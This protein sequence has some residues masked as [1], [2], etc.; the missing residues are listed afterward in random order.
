MNSIDSRPDLS[1]VRIY[2]QQEIVGAGFLISDKYILTCAHV[3]ATVLGINADSEQKPSE[4]QIVELDFPTIQPIEPLTATVEFWLPVNPNNSPEDIA[5]LKL[6]EPP[7]KESQ[8]AVLSMTKDRLSGHKFEALGFPEGRSGGAWAEG[9]INRCVGYGWIQLTDRQVPGYRLEEGFSGTP[10]WDNTIRAVVGIA[11]AADKGR[12]E[13]KAA[14]MIPTELVLEAWEKLSKVC[15]IVEKIPSLI[16]LLDPYFQDFK[17]RIESAYQQSLPPVSVRNFPNSLTDIIINLNSREND[18]EDDYSC[19][20]KFIGYL[21]LSLKDSVLET[22]LRQSLINWLEHNLGNYQDLL[23]LLKSKRQIEKVISESKE[24]CLLAAIF[25][26]NNSFTVQGWLID[27]IKSYNSLEE[28][29]CY[30]IL[31][32]EKVK[33]TTDKTLENLP[34]LLKNFYQQSLKTCNCNIKKVHVFLPY[35]LIGRTYFSID[36]L[37]IEDGNP[38]APPIGTKY[39]VVIRFSERLKLAQ[40]DQYS[41]V[42]REKWQ[43][44]KG[45]LE[46]LGIDILQLSENTSPNKLY[47]QLMPDEVVAARLTVPIPQA[48]LKS[49]MEVFYFAGIPIAL[50]LREEA[51]NLNLNFCQE[52]NNLCQQCCLENLPSSIKNRRYQDWDEDTNG[53]G[54][55]LSLLWDDF[56][57]VPKRE[58]IM[59]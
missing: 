47:K 56:D 30:P 23:D 43:I 49:I 11:V 35:S 8:A 5:V 21:L 57:L 48:K 50:W 24:P 52:L 38:F 6:T 4:E 18:S 9:F 41:I 54:N 2:K 15:K 31:V 1:V 42:Y 29:S 46:Q 39:E 58:L 14:F 26:D 16:A 25:D 51:K 7:P 20:E 44:A 32:D 33:L 55:H 17:R 3:V 27:D 53:I 22:Q 37:V 40:E 19:L 34:E 13:V 45:S 36:S 28:T 59:S 12:P 10:I